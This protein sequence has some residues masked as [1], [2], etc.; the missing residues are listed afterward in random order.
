MKKLPDPSPAGQ[1]SMT[2]QGGSV[3]TARKIKGC[4]LCPHQSSLLHGTVKLI[5]T[6][7]FLHQ[8]IF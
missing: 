2:L 7:C 8:A 3:G 5:W 4:L 1:G 6:L